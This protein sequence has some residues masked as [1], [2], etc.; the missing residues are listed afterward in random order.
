MS[1]HDQESDAGPAREE[2][3]AKAKAPR[4][5]EGPS[6]RAFVALSVVGSCAIGAAAAGPALVMLT[7]P[8][9]ASGDDAK[10]MFVAKLDELEPGV[11]KRVAIVGD[12]VDA[13]T[14]AKNRRL[15]AIWLVRSGAREVLAFSS[16]CPHLGCGIEATADGK[17]FACPCHTSFFDLA[18][19]PQTGP[20]PR[21]MD[22]LPV[23]IGAKGE[24][25]V[26]WKRFRIGTAVAEEL[27]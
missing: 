10:K 27:A 3:D 22:S 5:D 21:G 18:G 24:V 16:I 13:W 11:P 20:S 23:E 2:I 1:D 7:D 12:E 26:T 19:K 8:L 14:R 6:R 17:G 15:G 25:F 9:R 4:A